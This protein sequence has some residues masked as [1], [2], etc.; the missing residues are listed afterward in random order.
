MQY[1][2]LFTK[3]ELDIVL[4]ALQSLELRNIGIGDKVRSIQGMI[5]DERYTQ[6]QNKGV[7]P[8]MRA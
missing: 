4:M 8:R 7:L 3:E 2:V 1:Q 5:E 6:S